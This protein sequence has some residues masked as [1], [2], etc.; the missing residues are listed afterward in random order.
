MAA[1][2]AVVTMTLALKGKK[3]KE[4]DKTERASV[5]VAKAALCRFGNDALNSKN[6][7][8]VQAYILARSMSGRPRA[9]DILQILEDQTDDFTSH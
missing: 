1:C 5:P 7:K 6:P 2:C 9:E 3:G 4:K 8:H